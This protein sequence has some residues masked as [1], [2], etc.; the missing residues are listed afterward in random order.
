MDTRFWPALVVALITYAAV[1]TPT[2]SQAQRI[3]NSNRTTEGIPELTKPLGESLHRY[4]NTRG[5]LLAGWM[6]GVDGLLIRTRFGNTPQAHWVERPGGAR[7]QL[8]FFDDPVSAIGPNPTRPGFV[9]AKDTGGAEQWQ[10]YY[11]DFSTHDIRT[12]TDGKSRNETPVWSNHGDKLAFSSTSRNGSDS[13]IF[14]VGLDGRPARPVFARSGTWDA[15]DWS[16]DDRRIIVSEYV[17]IE[18]THPWVLDLATGA[19]V[20]LSDPNTKTFYS[21]IKFSKD[22]KGIFY[23]ANEGGEFIELRYRDLATG[24]IKRISADIS[25]DIERFTISK[26]GRRV[27]FIVNQDGISVLHLLDVASGRET[28]VPATPKGIITAVDF[29]S[30]GKRLAIALTSPISA[31]DVYVVDVNTHALVRWTTSEA[32]GLD[33]GQ[34]IEPSLIHFPTFDQDGG[35]PRR[36]SALFYKPP[37]AGPFPVVIQIHGGPEDQARPGFESEIQ[38]WVN[39]MKLAVLLP[40][41]RGSTGYGKTFLGLDNG[42]NRENAVKDIGCLLDWVGSQAVLDSHRVAVYGGS[43]GGFMVLSSLTHFSDRLRAGIEFVGQSNFVTYLEHTEA[44]RRDLRR[45]EYG[46]EREPKMREFLERIAPLSNADHIHVPLFVAV[47]ANDPRVPASEGEQIARA[48]R[49]NGVDV[50]FLKFA[51]EGHGF[52]KKADRELF[53]AVTA[54]FW[55]KKLLKAREPN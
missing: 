36:L 12:L 55:F 38:F 31:S 54:E 32:G 29:N 25:W 51:D 53:D 13:D 3:E 26:D 14:V 5:A 8:T 22:G 52:Q 24:V 19:A 43:Y 18:E 45:A 39:E 2:P 50:W 34:F 35:K 46:D 23:T 9:F 15:M 17:S 47:G 42:F 10:L 6:N 40:N 20:A 21:D 30:D 4:E 37:G 41:V 7:Q 1:G 44:Y 33:A 11:F 27:A 16:P 28:P 49:A 48:V